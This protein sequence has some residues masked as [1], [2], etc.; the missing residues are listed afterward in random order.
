MT[1]EEAKRKAAFAALDELPARGARDPLVVGLGTGSTAKLFVEELG[2][3]VKAGL[4]LVGVPTSEATRAQATSLGIPLL[5]NEGP[6]DIDVT[7]DGADEVSAALDLIKGGGAAHTREKIVNFASRRNVIIVDGS[8]MSGLLGE[9]WSVPIGC[10]PSR[11]APRAPR[12]PATATP[13]SAFAM[14][15]SCAPTRAT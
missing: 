7:V 4:K 10:S 1:P 15:P 2:A 12:W 5:D 11:T 13:C 9:R 8:K 14:A 3:R 6:W